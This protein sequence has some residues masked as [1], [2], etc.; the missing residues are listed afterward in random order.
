MALGIPLVWCPQHHA[1]VTHQPL[2]SL[3]FSTQLALRHLG[4]ST[5][6]WVG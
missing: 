2:D 4:L 3:W 1:P 6:Y 5:S